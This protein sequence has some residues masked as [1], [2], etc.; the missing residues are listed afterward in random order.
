LPTS[1]EVQQDEVEV[2]AWFTAVAAIL[3]G[4]AWALSMSV[5]RF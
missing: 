3:L 4:A 2:T 1:L 5:H